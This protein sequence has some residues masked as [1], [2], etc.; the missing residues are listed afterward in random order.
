MDKETTYKINGQELK[1]ALTEVITGEVEQRVYNRFSNRHVDSHT[2]CE[3]LGVS[4]ST[5]YRYVKENRVKPVNEHEDGDHLKFDLSEIL[6]LD[7]KKFSRV[8]TLKL[9]KEK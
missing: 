4:K 8:S 3:L 2:V 5:L 6:K 7:P 1:E 9:K